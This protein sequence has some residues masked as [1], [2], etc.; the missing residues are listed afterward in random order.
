ML[1]RL[2]IALSQEKAGHASEYLLS[3]TRQIIYSFYRTKEIT[4]N[5]YNNKLNKSIIQKWILCL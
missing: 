1:Q 2:Q 5:V 4:K 3:E